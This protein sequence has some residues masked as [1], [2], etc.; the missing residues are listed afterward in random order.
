[1]PTL[2]LQRVIAERNLRKIV[3]AFT[4]I[5]EGNQIT[6]LEMLDFIIL[7]NTLNEMRADLC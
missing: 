1:M 6:F 7:L 3:F 2:G 4:F 5:F